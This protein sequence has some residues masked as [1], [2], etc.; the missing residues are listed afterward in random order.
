MLTKPLAYNGKIVELSLYKQTNGFYTWLPLRVRNDKIYPNGYRIGIS[1]IETIYNKLTVDM[2]TN[3]KTTHYNQG[4]INKRYKQIIDK[5]D[6]DKHAP[7][8]I[9]FNIAVNSMIANN[10]CCYLNVVNIYYICKNKT[11][12]INNF[13]NI[14]NDGN[15][16][17]DVNCIYY[18]DITDLYNK[19]LYSS[20]V[21]KS[22]NLFIDNDDVI[23]DENIKYISN[24]MNYN[25]I[26]ININTKAHKLIR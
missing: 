10:I 9:V 26:Y 11:T 18:E 15:N 14:Q 8:N 25:G 23:N 17:I 3:N 12:L 2:L 6:F 13:N 21:P 5:L 4:S 7:V 1:N 24:V 22:I 19:L 16:I 20:F